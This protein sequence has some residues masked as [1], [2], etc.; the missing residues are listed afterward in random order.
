MFS[1]VPFITCRRKFMRSYM[2]DQYWRGYKTRE[3]KAPLFKVT[4]SGVSVLPSLGPC[5]TQI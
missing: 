2:G 3:I 4:H 1:C 5:S